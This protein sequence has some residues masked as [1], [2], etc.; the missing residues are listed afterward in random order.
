MVESE[1]QDKTQTE[2]AAQADEALAPPPTASE[3][4]EARRAIE[5]QLDAGDTDGAATSLT[6]LRPPDQAELLD[7]LNPEQHDALVQAISPS[8]LAVLLENLDPSNLLP[9]ASA[10]APEQL[11]EVLDATPPDVAADLL[12][13]MEWDDASRVL[14]LM[15]DRKGVGAVLIYPDENAGGIMSPQVAAVRDSVN[16]TRALSI[17]RNLPYPRTS[18]RDLFVVDDSGV[19]V[20]RLDLADLVFA[21][22]SRRIRDLMDRDVVYVETGTDQEECAR[23]MSRYDLRS[24]PVVDAAGHLEGAISIEDIVDVAEA[25]ATE[26]MYKMIGVEPGARVLGPI[27]EAV[28]SRFPWLIINLA[29]ALLSGFLLSLFASTIQKSAIVAAFV[30]TI[31][32]QGGIAGTQTLTL[33]VRSLA[34]GEV[35][36]GDALKLLLR[37]GYLSILQGVAQSILLGAIVWLWRD[38]FSL[39]LV[40]AI[41][42]QAN[43]L[44]AAFGGVLVPLGLKA[45]RIDPATSS[46]VIVTTLTD[47]AGIVVYLSIVTSFLLVF[48]S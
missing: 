44:V 21:H 28:R 9:V 33:I 31:T 43:L 35:T 19:L 26:D 22:P 10:L 14:A 47:S 8:D 5:E 46:A 4:D 15:R 1:V 27:K 41:A 18:V 38:D 45:V 6:E 24:L 39:G 3:L 30:P 34:L 40:V 36:T 48:R 17:L 13:S 32:G 11:A 20:G 25:E 12:R 42:L 29:T 7:G 37:E 2:E 16:V 23:L